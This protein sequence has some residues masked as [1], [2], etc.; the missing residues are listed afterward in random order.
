M[1]V[2]EGCLLEKRHSA[3]PIRLPGGEARTWL[4]NGDR[5]TLR[6]YAQGPGL[7]RIGLGLCSGT[8]S[9]AVYE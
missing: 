7:P 1:P 4:E 5:V 2:Q 8:I 9:G 6:V 3:E